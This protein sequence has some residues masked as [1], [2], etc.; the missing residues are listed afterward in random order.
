M[1]SI[2]TKLFPSLLHHWALLVNGGIEKFTRKRGGPE[3]FHS[4][5]SCH[6]GWYSYV[7]LCNNGKFGLNSLWLGLST[8]NFTLTS[9]YPF[10][11]YLFITFAHFL[12]PFTSFR[13]FLLCYSMSFHH[14]FSFPLFSSYTVPSS[15]LY[16]SSSP[17][18][19]LYPSI[20][21]IRS[22]LFFP[23][24]TSFLSSLSFQGFSPHSYI[25][26][27]AKPSSQ[28]RKLL[29]LHRL[30]SLISIL[31]ICLSRSLS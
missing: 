6:D 21:I 11:F 8:P 5:I 26:A 15:F 28:L 3:V 12:I 4:I 1:E 20:L 9:F 13:P 24:P 16:S 7:S 2:Q 29:P 22:P 25:L 18:F 27:S 23:L 14:L 10:T 31:Y 30:H 19:L 17:P